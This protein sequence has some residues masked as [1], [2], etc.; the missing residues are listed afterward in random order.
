MDSAILLN[1]ERDEHYRGKLSSVTGNAK[2]TFKVVNKLLN[3]EY[4]TNKVP[5]GKSDSEVANGLKDFFHSKITKI[6]SDIEK[7]KDIDTKKAKD[8][9]NHISTDEEVGTLSTTANYF[10]ILTPDEI[11]K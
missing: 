8:T 6:Y 3:K 1:R 2:E 5:N 7:A 11:T 9:C 10:K 4:G